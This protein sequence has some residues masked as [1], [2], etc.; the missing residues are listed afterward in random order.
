MKV[1]SIEN[2]VPAKE[3]A[4]REKIQGVKSLISRTLEDIRRLTHDLRPMALDDL[5]LASAIRAY[6]KNRLEA[7]DIQVQFESKGLNTSR[8]L[9]PAIETALFRIIQEAANNIAK[10]AD[11]HKV[12]IYLSVENE[13]I[14][15]V[16]EDDGKGF[17]PDSVFASGSNRPSLGL[18]GI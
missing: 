3:S 17:D 1:E 8:R 16:I 13:V 12:G 4:L 11:A 15:A 9:S 14:K 6:V 7:M 5:G 10:H 2:L 18:L